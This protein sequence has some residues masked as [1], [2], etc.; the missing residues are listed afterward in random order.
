[1]TMTSRHLLP[2]LLCITAGAAA[3]ATATFA[4]TRAA[5]GVSWAPGYSIPVNEG[6]SLGV[7]ALDNGG[8][9]FLTAALIG[10]DISSLAGQYATI[11][12]VT[13]TGTVRDQYPVTGT[14]GGVNLYR[15]GAGFGTWTT[16]A[17][18]ATQDGSA[19]WS[20]G[21]TMGTVD[22][23][24]LLATS[25]VTRGDAPGTAYTWT[26][27]GAA[28]LQLINDWTSGNN[29]GLS[30][31]DTGTGGGIDYR[32]N[33]GGIQGSVAQPALT[34]DYTPVPEPSGAVLA[35]AAGMFAMRRRRA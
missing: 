4:P 34:V 13:L 7:G 14:S 15:V 3:A 26:F 16:A 23:G 5:S 1:M 32:S 9:P 21:A 6:G 22:S 24:A 19:A 20:G 10:F 35:L 33:I 17:T 27:S 31:S 18:W 25:S 8:T 12:S 30:L 11:N 29:T 28:A 2:I